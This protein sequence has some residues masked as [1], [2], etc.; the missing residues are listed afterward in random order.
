MGTVQEHALELRDV[1]KWKR[2]LLL[3]ACPWC[4]ALVENNEAAMHLHGQWHVSHMVAHDHPGTVTAHPH[5]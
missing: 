2:V 1:S 3:V 4:S 5:D